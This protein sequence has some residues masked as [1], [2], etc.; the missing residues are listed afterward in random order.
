MPLS[1][2]V[3]CRYGPRFLVVEPGLTKLK[4]KQ[5]LSEDEYVKA[6]EQYGSDA[7]E[8]G[9][10]AEAIRELLLKLDLNAERKRLR[11]RDA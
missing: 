1:V 8:A 11:E 3:F 2:A 7:F 5:L 6:Q 4:H 9:I 10:G